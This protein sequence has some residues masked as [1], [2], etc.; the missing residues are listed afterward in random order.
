MTNR[1]FLVLEVRAGIAL[2]GA[3][4]FGY[5]I[6][7]DGQAYRWAGIA[8]FVLA[9]LLRW[10]KPSGPDERPPRHGDGDDAG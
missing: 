7:V 9:I 8:M 5:G 4:L 10:W 3:L 6:R 2:V 1:Q